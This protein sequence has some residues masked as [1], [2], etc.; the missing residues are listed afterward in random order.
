VQQRAGQVAVAE[1]G[2]GE[3]GAG[4]VALAHAYTHD[5]RLAQV[6]A[7]QP[8][9]RPVTAGHLQQA[10]RAPVEHAADQL[11]PGE[12]GVEERAVGERA[13][14]ERR[15]RV[16]GGVEA[17]VAEHALGERRAPVDDLGQVDVV[18]RDPGVLLPGDVVARP[19]LVAYLGLGGWCGGTV[20]ALS[21][22]QSP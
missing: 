1:R 13:V 15:V 11:A 20:P 14:D 8:D 2:A 17:A 19:V 7:G 3:L 18:E 22:E 4:E 6:G 5:L 16:R 10:E 21:H 12:R 9:E